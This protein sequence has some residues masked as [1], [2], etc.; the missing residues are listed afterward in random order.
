MEINWIASPNF[1]AGR[2][3]QK[4]LAIINHIMCGTE[5]GTDSW[6]RNPDSQVSAHFGVAKDGRVH[7]YVKEE[8]TAWANGRKSSPDTAWLA[9]FPAVNPNQWTISIEHEGYPQDGLTDAQKQATFEL[10]KQLVT[11]YNIPVDVTHITGHFRID[12]ATRADCPGDKFPFEELYAYLTP[13]AVEIPDHSLY[14]E[15]QFAYL[16]KTALA[17]GGEGEWAKGELSKMVSYVT[18][19]SYVQAPTGRKVPAVVV[20]NKVFVPV[21]DVLTMLG[22]SYQWIDETRTVKV[23]K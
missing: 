3:G 12:S 7:Q 16:V 8:D 13:P 6:F 4:P 9:N 11:K 10:H 22:H 19:G 17:G 2:S 21:A 23:I 18:N 1:T 14:D 15:N 5:E 20:Y